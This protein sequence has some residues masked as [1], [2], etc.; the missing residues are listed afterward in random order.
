MWVL[1]R[2]GEGVGRGG[3]RGGKSLWLSVGCGDVG[4]VIVQVRGGGVGRLGG[5][6]EG[7]SG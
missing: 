7:G 3:G 4:E 1:V 6:G 5:M 2:D